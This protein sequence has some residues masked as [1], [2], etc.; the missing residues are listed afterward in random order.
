M[1]SDTPAR[2]EICVSSPRTIAG[3]HGESECD[4]SR[5]IVL[6]DGR[7]YFRTGDVGEMWHEGGKTHLKVDRRR[8]HLVFETAFCSHVQKLSS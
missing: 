3:Y 2:G 4:D 1:T 8:V 6:G 5:F 7:R